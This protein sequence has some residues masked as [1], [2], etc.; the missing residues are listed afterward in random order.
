MGRNR[1][2]ALSQSNLHSLSREAEGGAKRGKLGAFRQ[3]GHT[4]EHMKDVMIKTYVNERQNILQNGNHHP[5][6]TAIVTY[7]CSRL[8]HN[9]RV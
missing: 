6:V 2:Q 4:E 3:N 1:P 9:N 8:R 5:Q 7:V